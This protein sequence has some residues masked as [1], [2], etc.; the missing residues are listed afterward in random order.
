MKN[1]M[2]VRSTGMILSWVGNDGDHC[3][4]S[5]QVIKCEVEAGTLPLCRVRVRHPGV[6]SATCSQAGYP[7]P[8]IVVVCGVCGMAESSGCG[9]RRADLEEPE[10]KRHRRGSR[11][12]STLMD[13]L[14]Q[15]GQQY[16][17]ETNTLPLEEM[18]QRLKDVDR[19]SQTLR[20]LI[21]EK[22]KAKEELLGGAGPGQAKKEVK[23]E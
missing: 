2:V 4:A 16:A 9:R 5:A 7:P 8:L 10:V 3:C 21:Q 15:W 22:T 14:P 19:L 23:Q 20:R 6:R 11:S 1:I 17:H 12:M 18:R 13:G